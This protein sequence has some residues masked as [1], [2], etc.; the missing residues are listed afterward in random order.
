MTFLSCSASCTPRNSRALL[1]ESKTVTVQKTH[2]KKKKNWIIKTPKM[3]KIKNKKRKKER[4]KNSIFLSTYLE[5]KR[6]WGVS[7][8]IFYQWGCHQQLEH[9]TATLQPY[10]LP[11]CTQKRPAKRSMSKMKESE[12]E[13]WM[14]MGG[15]WS[16]WVYKWTY[17]AIMR[18]RSE[19]LHPES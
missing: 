2:Q 3:K 1:T 19:R 7:Q 17:L 15:R 11:C 6:F 16:L 14:H 13:R 18:A 9:E 10:P 12:N 4:K 8:S 5:K